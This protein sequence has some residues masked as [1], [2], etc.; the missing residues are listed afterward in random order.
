MAKRMEDNKCDSLFLWSLVV[1]ELEFLVDR[2]VNI[3]LILGINLKSLLILP[4]FVASLQASSVTDLTFTLINGDTEYS[5]SD[6]LT[7]ASGSLEIPSTNNGLPVTSIG[8]QAFSNC[9]CLT[10]IS[11]SNPLLEAA[12]A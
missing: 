6:C 7:S 8:G 5:V 12:E 9:S 4:F 10:S 3:S 2:N 11:F 1:T